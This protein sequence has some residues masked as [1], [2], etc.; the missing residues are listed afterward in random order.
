MASNA[1]HFCN[2]TFTSLQKVFCVY[3][4]C[5]HIQCC[6]MDMEVIIQCARSMTYNYYCN[7]NLP[8]PHNL[9]YYMAIHN[10]DDRSLSDYVDAMV[11]EGQT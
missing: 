6:L 3:F 9:E 1:T 2:F 7:H 10:N 4:V 5:G 11:D 8:H